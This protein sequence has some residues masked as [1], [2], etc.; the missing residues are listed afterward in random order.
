MFNRKG[1]NNPENSSAT[2][3]GE[4]VPSVFSM[5][6]VSSFKSKK[7]NKHDVYRGKDCMKKFF[8]SSREHATKITNLKEKKK[9]V[10][11]NRTAGII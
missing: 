5:S 9:E 8:E 1:K 4:H 2:K 6:A 10:I 7:Q 3:V 11:N